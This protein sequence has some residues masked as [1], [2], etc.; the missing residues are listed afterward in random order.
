MLITL[1]PIDNARDI[2]HIDYF[3]YNHL[4]HS[5]KSSLLITQSASSSIKEWTSMMINKAVTGIE[6]TWN[7]LLKSTVIFGFLEVWILFFV[8]FLVASLND[9]LLSLFRSLM[10][11]ILSC[12]GELFSSV[13]M[14]EWFNLSS[15]SI[16][17]A[18][19]LKYS[20]CKRIFQL[21][22]K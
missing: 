14:S 9:C 22:L 8:E 1:E 10:P 18:S 13:N 21:L 12:W 3:L 19:L 17:F 2:I 5:N 6:R 7:F 4:L 20:H 11:F 16:G 15:S